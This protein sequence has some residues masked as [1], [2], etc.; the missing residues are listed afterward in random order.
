MDVRE[1]IVS[2]D[3]SLAVGYGRIINLAYQMYGRDPANPTPAPPV[4]FPAGYRFIA[5]VQMKDFLLVE[6]DD[7]TFYGLIVQSTTDES[8]FILAIRGTSNLT[9][10][11]DDLTS[12]VLVPLEGFGNVGYGFS[13][14]YQTLRVVDFAPPLHRPPKR[15]RARCNL[16]AHLHIKWPPPSSG[17]PES[18][19]PLAKRRPKLEAQS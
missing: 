3:P 4:D 14:I 9:E 1:S 13:R 16:L 5:W 18:P 6:D 10:W 2:Y 15:C 12:M 11:W 17:M 8:K 7:W 19:S